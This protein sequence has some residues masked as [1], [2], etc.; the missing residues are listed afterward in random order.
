MRGRGPTD[1]GAFTLV[2]LLVV[3]GIIALLISILLPS[4]NRAREQARQVACLSNLR[5]VG[6]AFVMYS[7]E[8]KGKFPYHAD[9]NGQYPEDWIHWQT[10]ARPVENSAVAPYIGKFVPDVFRCPGD[11][12]NIRPRVLTP[13]PYV[14]SYT[15]NLLFSSNPGMPQIVQGRIRNASEKIILVEEDEISIDDGNFHP[16]LV[17]TNIENY[18]ATR[19]SRPRRTDWQNWYF[20]D[21]SQRPDRE[22][23]G[24]AAFADG[25]GEYVTRAYTWDPK[26][27]D[28]TVE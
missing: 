18:L 13:I 19:H 12:I 2:E 24:N 17:R 25:H 6:L 26:H 9:L 8:N 11:D 10:G 14:Y 22:E 16:Q 15:F 4:L 1:R 5:Q 23:R 27:Y 3:I 28:P 7:N 20:L 21:L